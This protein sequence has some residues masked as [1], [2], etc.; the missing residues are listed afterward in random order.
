MEHKS[1]NV[2]SHLLC[3]MLRI[4]SF[5]ASINLVAAYGR[6]REG[7]ECEPPSKDGTTSC[8]GAAGGILSITSLSRLHR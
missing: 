2:L 1:V 6:Y 5:S 8:Q 7:S 4:V 3:E